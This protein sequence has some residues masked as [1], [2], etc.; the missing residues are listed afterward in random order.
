MRKSVLM[1]LGMLLLA[2]CNSAKKPTGIVQQEAVRTP[3]LPLSQQV[4]DPLPANAAQGKWII[5]SA[6]RPFVVHR[7]AFEALGFKFPPSDETRRRLTLKHI[8]TGL[9]YQITFSSLGGDKGFF[10][11]EPNQEIKLIPTNDGGLVC[12]VGED[13]FP[14]NEENPVGDSSGHKRSERGASA[15]TSTMQP[16]VINGFYGGMT[17]DEG[18]GVMSKGH[19]A[20]CKRGGGLGADIRLTKSCKI[21]YGDTDLGGPS[22]ISSDTMLMFYR[23]RLYMISS[24]HHSVSAQ[25]EIKLAFGKPQ[26]MADEDSCW[27]RKEVLYE[28]T[29]NGDEGINAP[30]D[31]DTVQVVDFN[32][33]PLSLRAQR[34]GNPMCGGILAN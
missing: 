19:K 11:I 15:A 1:L 12:K 4:N 3:E 24:N 17:W 6:S 13:G 8:D 7:D 5:L 31:L 2:G 9:Q 22:G 33:A 14:I 25:N 18:S 10:G 16:V 21:H 27:Y 30:S 28:V 26:K 32:Y 20:W 34:K 23:D 29:K